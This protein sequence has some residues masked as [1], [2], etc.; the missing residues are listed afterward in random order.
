[1][2]SIAFFPDG[3][4]IISGGA[5]NSIRIWNAETGGLVK[6][7]AAGADD[8]TIAHSVQLSRDGHSVLIESVAGSGELRLELR[9]VRTG[10]V[11]RKFDSQHI[12]GL[13]PILSPDSRLVL[14]AGPKELRLWDAGTGKLLRRFADSGHVTRTVAYSPDGA[15]IAS[16]GDDGAIRI[17]STASGRLLRTLKA[18]DGPQPANNSDGD[19]VW[20]LA[21]TRNGK[22]IVAATQR[23]LSIRDAQSGEVVRTFGD[24]SRAYYGAAF[25]PDDQQVVSLSGDNVVRAWNVG[26][27]ELAATFGGAESNI[28]AKLIQYGDSLIAADGRR[29]TVWNLQS[30][31]AR[32]MPAGIQ[33][34]LARSSVGRLIVSGGPDGKLTLRDDT[35]GAVVR[36]LEGDAGSPSAI[37]F[38]ADGSRVIAGTSKKRFD[39]TSAVEIWD[40]RTGKLLHE[41]HGHLRPVRQLALSPDGLRALSVDDGPTLKIWDVS[42]RSLPGRLHGTLF[43][44][45]L[46][47]YVDTTGRTAAL[48]PD[49]RELIVAGWDEFSVLN[50]ETGA[51][52]RR[53]PRSDGAR[54]IFALAVAPDGRAFITGGT[55]HSVRLLS[56]HTGNLVRS[57]DG[58]TAPVSELT[59]SSDGHRIISSAWDGAVRI[60]TRES[61]EL[62]ATFLESA[63]GEWLTVT[64]DGFFSTGDATDH[65]LH[66]VRGLSVTR[67]DQVHQS[68]YSPDLVREALAG[69]INGEV[70]EAARVVD[71][72]RVLDSGPPPLITIVSHGDRSVSRGDLVTVRARVADRGKGVGRIE[73]RVNG[74]T[75]AVATSKPSSNGVVSRQIALQGG[76]STIE[77][78]AYNSSNLV[79][80]LPARITIV[81]EGSADRTKPTMHILAIGINAYVDK[82]WT[83]PGKAL[84]QFAPLTLAVKDATTLGADLKRAAA[85]LYDD[86]RVTYALDADATR[87]NLERIIDKLGSE[88]HPRDTFVLFAAA[89]GT[90]VDGRFFLI[91]QD[92]Q[93]GSNPDALSRLA[94]GQDRLQ[95]WLANRIRATRAIV[96]LDT[97]ESGALVGGHRRS[98]TGES[99]TESAIG[100]LHEAT[101]RPILTAAAERQFAHEG[102]IAES[103]ERHGVFTWAVLDALRKGDA[104][105]D[106]QI[107][108]SELVEH[109]QTVVPKVAAGV[110]RA[111]TLG[112]VPGKQTARFGSR[113][114]NFIVS[115]RAK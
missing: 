5:D 40:A 70:R 14:A 112:P 27:G 9:D 91:P 4:R 106:G 101:G 99:A 66:I 56:L 107:D 41:L 48:S 81:R 17:W 84:E 45:L 7:Y 92:Y 33:W 28:A 22:R 55:D 64:R 52:V 97:C 35:S 53:F 12:A 38:S 109:V 72:D 78:V 94:I 71:L 44:R 75:S 32:A 15:E 103:G 59:F 67:I 19:K 25:S 69:D 47:N 82:G 8:A 80:S 73:W 10:V 29:A 46:K 23:S 105:G 51:V 62:L 1:V 90:S 43:G 98:R 100:R 88:I 11:L 96:L 60:W 74:I 39:P 76:E 26:S 68:L 83:P 18:P 36:T 114:E 37:A 110:V 85:P 115:Q 63:P 16:G 34:P 3:G 86:V 42:E 108:L 30:G 21:F 111:A 61:G 24:V 79:A 93:G 20:G 49:L 104:N 89:H 54:L 87:A 6:R 31:R 57:F 113:G 102:L 13:K 65:K 2:A 77:V 95:D 58:G 50:L